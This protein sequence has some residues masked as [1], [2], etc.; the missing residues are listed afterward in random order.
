MKPTPRVQ[1]IAVLTAIG[2]VL[3]VLQ[4]LP[5]INRGIQGLDEPILPVQGRAGGH[6]VT[7]VVG[8]ALLYLSAQLHRRKQRAW[9]LSI[10]LFAV[11]AVAHALKGPNFYSG[12]FA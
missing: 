8:V 2:G 3:G 11:T 1:L 5:V 12:A 10:V 7:L 6:I 4:L 9:E